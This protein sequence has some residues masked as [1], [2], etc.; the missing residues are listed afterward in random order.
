M[1]IQ[2]LNA[3]RY[4]LFYETEKFK[5]CSDGGFYNLIALY[6]YNVMFGPPGSMVKPSCLLVIQKSFSNRCF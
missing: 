5:I 3:F 4:S 6:L 1:C 2:N